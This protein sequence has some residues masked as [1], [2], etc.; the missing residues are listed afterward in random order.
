MAPVADEAPG[1]D[2][3]GPEEMVAATEPPVKALR[4]KTVRIFPYAVSKAKLERALRKFRVSA[5]IVE[6]LDDADMVVTLKA[7]ERRQPRRLRDAHARGIPFYVV[8]SNTIT[9][10]ENFLGT[11][12]GVDDPA[13]GD[14]AA[15]REVEEG[16][17]EALEQGHP[18]ELSPQ[19]NHLRRLQHQVVE[20]YGLTSESRGEE[21]YRR[22]VIQPKEAANG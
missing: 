22:V 12:F 9:Q 21:P 7:Q 10:M 8:R 15:L 4:G 17:D 20:R 19:N 18:V 2:R 1:E 11:V 5:Y 3:E 6:D 14:E 13:A 16:I